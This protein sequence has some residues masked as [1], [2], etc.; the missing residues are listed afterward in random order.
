M[1]SFLVRK[2]SIFVRS[3]CSFSVSFSCWAWS[4]VIWVSSDCSSVCASVLRSSAIRARSSRP[5]ESA[6]RAWVS[7]LTTCCSSFV[8]CICRRFLA[9]TTSAMPFLTFWSISTC[10][11]YP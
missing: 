8:F 10:F 1:T 2:A 7:S 6:W 4:S 9:V 11:W 3:F 5:C